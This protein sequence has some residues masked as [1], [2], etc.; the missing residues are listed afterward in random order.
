MLALIPRKDLASRDLQ[1]F[2]YTVHPIFCPNIAL[3]EAF[4]QV[5]FFLFGEQALLLKLLLC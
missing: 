3:V 1:G 4:L 5:F 2:G